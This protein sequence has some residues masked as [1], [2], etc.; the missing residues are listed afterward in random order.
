VLLF[1]DCHE[2]IID[3]KHLLFDGYRLVPPPE[4]EDIPSELILSEGILPNHEL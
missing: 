2:A 3:A 1:E 4:E